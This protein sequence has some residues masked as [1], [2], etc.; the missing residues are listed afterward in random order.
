MIARKFTL[1]VSSVLMVISSLQVV[2][3]SKAAAIIDDSMITTKIKAKML[4]D[5]VV[6]SLAVSV[7]TKEGVVTLAGSVKT[8]LEATQVVEL[9]AS[10]PGVKNVDAV[11]LKMEASAQPL[12]DAIITG[13]V[14]G[15]FVRE[16]LFGDKL[17]SVT[18]VKVETK[19]GVVYLSGTLKSAEESKNAAK[20]A[21]SVEGVTKVESTITV[22]GSK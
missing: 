15:A 9:A 6:H 21:E 19:G 20:L 10:T 16:K 4:A 3:E 14:K 12:T 5:K 7:A 18:S 2:A 17:S 13:K 11:G 8:E 22:K 1:F